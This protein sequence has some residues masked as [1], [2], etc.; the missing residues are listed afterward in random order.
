MIS[1]WNRDGIR[2]NTLSYVGAPKC[3]YVLTIVKVYNH[4]KYINKY[5]V[6]TCKNTSMKPKGS[7][8]STYLVSQQ[9]E[10][11]SK[12][13]VYH[14]DNNINLKYCQYFTR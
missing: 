13:Y 11:L 5:A 1:N 2:D 6:A 3:S 7:T 10:D 8:S 4:Y 14:R 9:N 12:Q